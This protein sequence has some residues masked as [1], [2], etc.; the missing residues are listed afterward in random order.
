MH[1][2][3]VHQLEHVRLCVKKTTKEH[4]IACGGIEPYFF[5]EFCP[6]QCKLPTKNK[7]TP[8]Q[9]TNHLNPTK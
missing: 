8:T 5:I 9:T 7:K 6:L 3:Y 4:K 1:S 2:G